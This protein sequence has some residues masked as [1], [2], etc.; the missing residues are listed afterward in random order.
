MPVVIVLES[1]FSVLIAGKLKHMPPAFLI[2]GRLNETT[3]LEI[4]ACSQ[5]QR[6]RTVQKLN[7]RFVCR[8]PQPGGPK[9][10]H[11]QALHVPRRDIDYEILDA[12]RAGGIA[13]LKQIA[14]SLYVPAINELAPRLHHRPRFANVVMERDGWVI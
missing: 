9:Y 12:V 5:L 1:L 4:I 7:M 13:L 8:S 6:I 2:I 11:Q 10:S 3:T 14:D